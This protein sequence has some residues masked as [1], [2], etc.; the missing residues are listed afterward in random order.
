MEGYTVLNNSGEVLARNCTL[1][2]AAQTVL[3][4]DG[5]DYEIRPSIGGGFDLWV[6]QFSRNSPSGG[7]PMVKSVIQAGWFDRL[8]EAATN[9]I[10]LDI[11]ARADMW[12]CEVRLDSEY[13]K[14]I[15][16]LE[17][18]ETSNDI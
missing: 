5:H 2:E 12:H 16:R 17:Q 14:M 7:M 15:T 4:Y 1:A 11:I 3:Y 13:D 8:A 10:Y 18:S 6:T 9:E